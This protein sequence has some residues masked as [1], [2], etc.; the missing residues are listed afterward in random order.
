MSGFQ[1]PDL[2]ERIANFRNIYYLKL[3]AHSSDS[4]KHHK[5]CFTNFLAYQEVMCSLLSNTEILNQ[6]SFSRK[7]KS[8]NKKV[9][10]LHH[11]EESDSFPPNRKSVLTENSNNG[12]EN[13]HDMLKQV[14]L[15]PRQSNSFDRPSSFRGQGEDPL[16]EVFDDRS[17]HVPNCLSYSQDDCVN[18]NTSPT[19]F[20]KILYDQRARCKFQTGLIL[21]LETLRHSKA[22]AST[23]GCFASHEDGQASLGTPL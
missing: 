9:E 1:N 23:V 14:D 19:L 12:L 10:T 7:I 13:R 17:F 2:S 4:I 6:R 5:M 16:F 21:A 8:P 22:T 20:P 3:E 18:A 15:L 11:A